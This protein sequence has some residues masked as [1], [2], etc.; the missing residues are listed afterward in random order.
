MF[1]TRLQV[2]RKQRYSRFE[3]LSV[4]NNRNKSMQNLY[5]CSRSGRRSTIYYVVWFPDEKGAMIKSDHLIK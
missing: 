4:K 2:S 5:F 3:E 1:L